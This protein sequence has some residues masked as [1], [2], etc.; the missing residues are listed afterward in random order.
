[1]KTSK[2]SGNK[3]KSTH[4]TRIT[5]LT[6]LKNFYDEQIFNVLIKD[7]YNS[8]LEVSLAAISASGSLGNEAA[9]QPLFDIIEKGK[10][11]QQKA[12]ISTLTRI[13]AP[14]SIDRMAEYFTYFQDNE[15][16]REL[17]R[18]ITIIS[19]MHP[20]T[21]ELTHALLQDTAGGQDYYDIILPAVLESGESELVKNN[22]E[23][24]NPDVQRFVFAKLLDSTPESA[25]PFIER[26]QD[27]FHQFDPH[28]LGCYLCAYELKIT[29]PRTNMVIDTLQSADPRATTSFVMALSGYQG[30]VENPQRLYRLLLKIPYVDMESESLTGDFLVKIVEEVKQDSPLLLNEFAFSTAT[31]L[32]AVF[33]KLKNQFV[34]LRGVKGKDALLAVVFTKILEQYATPEILRD[35]QNFFKSDSTSDAASIITRLRERMLAAPE[36]DRNRLE[37]GRRLFTIDDRVGRL[38]IFQTLSKANISTPTLARRLNR[39]VRLIG[40]LEIRNSGKKVLEILNFA[41]EER[42]P[43]LEETCVVTLCQLLNRT[44]IEHAQD[45]FAEPGKYPISLRAYV[46]G[47]RFV[48]AKL[49]LPPVLKLLLSPKLPVKIRS[50]AVDTLQEMNLTGM[51][52]ALPALVRVLTIKE[53]DSG[54]KKDIASI[55]AVH[56]D[57]GLFQSLVDLTNNSDA[58]VRAM[59]VRILKALARKD[60]NISADVLTNRLYLLLEDSD[61]ASRIEALLA[62]LSVGDDYAIQ[63][64]DD[65]IGTEDETASVDILKNLDQEISHELMAKILKL[66]YAKSERVHEE[67]RRVLPPLCQG[68]LAEDIRNSLLE[69]LKI[70]GGPAAPAAAPAQPASVPSRGIMERA[71]LDFKL[72]R[73][74]AQV[75]TVFFIDISGFTKKTLSA[76]AIDLMTLVQGFE[77]ITLPTIDRLKGSVVKK[78]GDGLLAVFKHPLNAALASLEIQ[79]Q[80][81]E[82]NEFKMEEERFYVRIGLNTGRVIRKEGD[83]FGDTV[84][85][86]S[87]MENLADPGDIYLTQA[88]YEEIKEY[89]RC[90]QLGQLEVKGVAGGIIAYSAQEPLIDIDKVISEPKVVKEAVAGGTDAGSLLNLKES[91]FKPQF[92]LPGGIKG[93]SNAVLASLVDLFEDLSKAVED[94]SENYH[95][96]YVFKRYL[97]DKWDEILR[98]SKRQEEGVSP[99]ATATV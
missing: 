55:I 56:A 33:A 76:K 90:T 46:R 92:N 85:V 11:A 31:N 43:Y 66:L 14:S 62:L 80:I 84:N 42:V 94:I 32:E 49:F 82:H 6:V 58:I 39:L 70:E 72:R 50:L 89:V 30:R 51:K 5:A 41:R 74:S 71:K 22:L 20:K 1:M 15:I 44:A 88:T 26:F 45:V 23:K 17:L 68:P 13:N 73:E 24:A 8:D 7:F 65:Y 86:A 38:N 9:I 2:M 67:L 52:A 18:A 79:R 34:S 61:H 48:P 83:V 96:D 95:D 87:R 99:A 28:T 97:Q 36:D 35:T 59:G 37:A 63:I 57:S 64:L 19:P 29:N 75:L 10:P 81:R 40:A 47:A 12:A 21:S 53:I 78:M 69:A 3:E 93:E 25:T 91:M 60:K 77:K 4:A 54:L 16:R 27:K 98:S